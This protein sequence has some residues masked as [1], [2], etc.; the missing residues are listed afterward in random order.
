MNL[1]L[2]ATEL[3]SMVDY[4]PETGL[5]LW[6]QGPSRKC[7]AGDPIKG[8]LQPHGYIKIG[9]GFK[10]YYAH[11]LAWLYMVG[12]WPEDRID[13][14]NGVRSDNRFANLREAT[15]PQNMINRPAKGARR[16]PD[17]RWTAQIGI[18]MRSV[19]L[20]SFDSEQEAHSAY[21]RAVSKY[22]GD[23]WLTR[24]MAPHG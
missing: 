13:H 5:F 17:G 4:C 8:S 9:L 14:K 15:H 23:E 1:D 18:N 12:R 3:R 11:R 24:K 10:R 7:K 22:H 20:G 21:L 19:Y 16:H 2:T 6:K